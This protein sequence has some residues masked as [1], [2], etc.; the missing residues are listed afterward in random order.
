[1]VEIGTSGAPFRSSSLAVGAALA[2]EAEGAH[3]IWYANELAAEVPI[4]QWR[5]QAGALA[6]IAPDPTDLAD[7]IV[8]VTA[9]LLVARRLRAGVLG[10]APGPDPTRAARTIATLADLAPGRAVVACGGTA[11]EIVALAG[12]LRPDLD[13]ELVG[14]GGAPTTAARLGWG[15]IGIAQ[16]PMAVAKQASDA[17]VTG[18]L[19]VH[20]PVLIH[21]DASVARAALEAPLLQAMGIEALADAVVVGTHSVLD[22]AIDRYV[23]AGVTRIILENLLP[24]GAPHQL[25]ASRAGLRTSIR[26]ARLRHRTPR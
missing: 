25:E 5:D 19:G 7:P 3:A 9:A 2:A 23:D 24:F 8:T 21:S 13:L 6:A 20:V 15:W 1:M 17:G 14:Y 10:W 12:A 16:S 11:E 26:S 22:T 18:T 4:E